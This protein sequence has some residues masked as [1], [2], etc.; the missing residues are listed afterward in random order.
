MPLPTFVDVAASKHIHHVPSE[1]S[2]KNGNIG[3]LIETESVLFFTF[4]IFFY[5]V[6]LTSFLFCSETLPLLSR[7]DTPTKHKPTSYLQTSANP[8]SRN[9]VSISPLVYSASQST[10]SNGNANSWHPHPPGAH[11]RLRTLGWLEYHLPD[12]TVYY[13][14]PTNRVTTE[15]NLRSEK[16][17]TDVE[18]FLADCRSKD[19]S[20][21]GSAMME[22]TLTSGGEIWLRDVG[23]AKSGL[24]LERWWVD[25]RSRTVVM[26]GDEHEHDRKGSG[27]G[28]AKKE[29]T[30]NS[31]EDRLSFFLLLMICFY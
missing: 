29:D 6:S 22:G 13:V 12:G 31:E 18:R 10:T 14:H 9:L 7:P 17:L 4:M 20:G 19:Q 26:S 5:F 8:Q 15:I 30:V 1:S 2:L 23:T 24:V 11:P 27:K 25:H 21:S 28:K 3:N 16:M